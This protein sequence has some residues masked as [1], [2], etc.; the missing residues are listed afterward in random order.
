MAVARM[1]G[2]RDVIVA[3]QLQGRFKEEKQGKEKGKGKAKAKG[4]A[5]GIQ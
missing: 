3:V 1:M 2:E 4:T 5:D